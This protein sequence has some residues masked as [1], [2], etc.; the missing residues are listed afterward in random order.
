MTTRV[1]NSQAIHSVLTTV[2]F[3]NSRY[4]VYSVIISIFLSQ[5][6]VTVSNG[7]FTVFRKVNMINIGFENKETNIFKG[8]SIQSFKVEG[9]EGCF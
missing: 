6:Q 1:W 9:K 3:S 4:S 5:P 7:S 2:T 8:T